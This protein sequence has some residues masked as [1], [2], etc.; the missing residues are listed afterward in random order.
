MRILLAEDEK[1]LS[2]ALVAILKHNNYS[3]DNVYNGDD[4]LKYATTGK[5]DIIVLDIMMPG[6]SG[7]EALK[8][9]RKQGVSAPIL[10]LTAKCELEDK[11]EGLDAGADDYLTKPFAMSELLARLRA[12]T[13]RATDYAPS[14]LTFGDL[15]LNRRN[16][17]LSTEHGSVRLP[18]KEF[19]II[20][21]LMA[22]P[23]ML[24]STEKFMKKIWGFD[25][26]TEINVVW[27]YISY[28]RRKLTSIKSNVAIQAARGV[29]Y[30]LIY[31]DDVQEA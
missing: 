27:V 4:A 8:E 7:I 23:N 9:M 22:N 17:Q 31:D 18:S 15:T 5:Y 30:C 1:E 12:M 24:I 16:F 20:E 14:E 19:Q 11:I 28:L 26:D 25:T 6:L 13:R 21:Y 29:G 2:N 10:L 3:I